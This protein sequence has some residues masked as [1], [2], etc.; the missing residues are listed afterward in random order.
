MNI[1]I[2]TTWFERGAAYVSKM[3]MKALQE[4][5]NNVYIYARGG[6]KFEKESNEWNQSNVTWGL[7][8]LG[9]NINLRH[10]EK[11]IKDNSIDVIFFNEQREFS[12]VA[13]IKKR[14]NNLKL[15]AYIDY[16]TEEM[17]PYYD[18]FDFI[19][20]NTKR[21]LEAFKNNKVEK[22]YIKWGTDID[23]YND[24]TNQSHDLVTFFH[25]MGM[26]NR[27]GTELLIN[28]FITGELYK[29]SKLIIHTQKSIEEAFNIKTNGLDKYNIQIIED[30]VGAPGL[31]YLGDVYV[32]PT[33]LEGLGLTLYEALA[34]GLPV[35]TTDFPPMNEVIDNC[36]GKLVNV[37][38][39]HS[40]SDGYYWPLAICDEK[41]LIDQ[42]KYYIDNK[43]LI[44]QLKK[45]ARN[46]AVK[47]LNF[48]DR[49]EEINNIFKKAK[50]KKLDM[51]L[52]N[53]IINAKKRNKSK[54]LL[55]GLSNDSYIENM[56]FN[57]IK[58][59]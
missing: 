41:S 22:Y 13:E 1:G 48:N 27:K 26:S 37:C 49:Y 36:N 29:K 47:E 12:I 30:T 3:Y 2:V 31:Y 5:G 52:Y 32:Y 42:M 33:K 16:Y 20:C 7:N 55:Y 19:I 53:K 28:A 57:I 25:S 44:E 9:T 45:D 59:K 15:G 18:I 39:L 35:I 51:C 21:H 8:L 23:L 46:F 14:H 10:F 24:D 4:T 56:I 43:D 34:S 50:I 17:L 40:R 54:H 38:Q 11:W 58:K 6:E